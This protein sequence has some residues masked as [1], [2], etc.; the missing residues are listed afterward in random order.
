MVS[1]SGVSLV[2]EMRRT[3]Q[4]WVSVILVLDVLLFR[5]NRENVCSHMYVEPNTA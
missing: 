1:R 4:R 2:V 3:S 5:V